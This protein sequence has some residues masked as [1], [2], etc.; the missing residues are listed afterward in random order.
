[1][2][3]RVFKHSHAHK[4]ED[5]ERLKW[6]PPADVLL[7]LHLSRG[8]RVADI[9]AGTGYFSFPLAKEIGSAGE[10]LAVDLQQEML[11]LLRQKLEQ[12]ESPK[13]ISLHLGTAS[14]LPLPDNSVDLAFYANI[15]HELNDQDAA[16]REARR[17]TLS[18]GRIAILDWRSDKDS[19][20]GP[21]QAHR[22]SAE[23]IVNLLQTN[24]CHNVACYNVGQY[25]YLVTAEQPVKQN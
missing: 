2:N 13:N 17:I 14:H 10:V 7:R 3:D 20:P 9:G 22:I 11:D 21:P 15:W 5:P 6:L 4:L 19:P 23:T 25:I 16:L 18:Q 8:A 1:M 12:S 24:R